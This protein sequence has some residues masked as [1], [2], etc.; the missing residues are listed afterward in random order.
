MPLR[1]VLQV[2]RDEWNA[3]FWALLYAFSIFLAYYILRPVRDEISAADRGNLQVI[4]TVVFLV[5]LVAVPLYS[6]V[7]ARLPRG[8]FVPRVNRFF[9]VNLLLFYA[10][11]RL[12]PIGARPW[13]DRVF[14]VWAS[15]F[16]L[17]AVTVF[18]G[19]M[20]DL[21]TSE[22]GKRLFAPITVGSSLG[23]IA[24]S[25]LTAGLVDAL[26]PFA[27]L[28]LACVPLEVAAWAAKALDHRAES[29]S[30]VLRREAEPVYGG[31]W[32][33]I[34]VVFSSPYLRR[35][36]LYIVLMTFAS[37]VL[38]FQQAHLIGNAMADRAARTSLFARMDL[39][40]NGITIF[41]QGV[42]TAHVI[43]RIGLGWSLAIVPLLAF[44][45]FLALGLFPTLAI[46][47]TVQI[48]YRSM[49]YALAKPTR[50]VLF[51]VVSREEKYKSKAFLDAA[52]Y[53]G[54]DLTS[55]WVYAGLAAAGLA[56]GAI[57]LVAVPMAG[58]WAITGL[59]LGRR[60]EQLARGE[61]GASGTA[62]TAP[63]A[64]VEPGG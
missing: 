15:V 38:Y 41:T 48:A 28:L 61:A 50:E 30:G 64:A 54:G 32:T 24:G 14:Y 6:A 53:R 26:P 37:T 33:G 1:G 43:R 62:G 10:A 12:L 19:F 52:I 29:A 63:P 49:R 39:A 25:S 59:Q 34:Q 13:I 16:A 11:L 35:I 8:V 31:V 17:F 47:I 36:A 7:V 51:T 9:I 2:R 21:W 40:V 55:G 22:Q 42:V 5:M 4:W 3:L 44:A 60:Q 57:A 45:G 18:W 56:I 23:A 20:A 27:L 46:L 58:I